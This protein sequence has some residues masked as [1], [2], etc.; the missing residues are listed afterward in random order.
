MKNVYKYG[1]YIISVKICRQSKIIQ[2]QLG[3]VIHF[4]GLKRLKQVKEEK[5]RKEF[6]TSNAT[7]YSL[8][9]DGL[10]FFALQSMSRYPWDSI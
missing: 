3:K 2:A 4:L 8:S 9:L 10:K 7:V 6:L 1:S 5:S